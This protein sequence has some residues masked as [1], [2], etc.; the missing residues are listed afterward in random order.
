MAS[1]D[2]ILFEPVLLILISLAHE[3][4][5]GYAIMQDVRS[6]TGWEMRAG[7]LY[8]ALAR[9]DRWGWIEEV[10]TDE[11]RRRPYRLTRTGRDE[12]QR[13]MILLETLTDESVK[14]MKR[15][16]VRRNA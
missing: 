15:K 11:Y 12:M 13:Q 10:P 1:D 4:K 7:T 5:H 3:A 16:P 9:M 14:R 6:L 2:P 8:G